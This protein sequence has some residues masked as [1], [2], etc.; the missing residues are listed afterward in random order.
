LRFE[1]DRPDFPESPGKR[2]GDTP[3]ATGQVE[4][5][6]LAPDAGSSDQVLQEYARIGD[7]IAGI[8]GGHTPEGI[9]RKARLYKI[10]AAHVPLRPSGLADQRPSS[11]RRSRAT[12]SGWPSATL[13]ASPGSA[14]RS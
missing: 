12:I 14:S 10:V 8:V 7:T 9:L 13:R 2:K 1:I 4:E 5:V 11:S 6:P 3:G